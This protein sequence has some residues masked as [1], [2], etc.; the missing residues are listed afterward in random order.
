[1]G[2]DG[3]WGCVMWDINLKVPRC[4]WGWSTQWST[5]HAASQGSRVC[6]CVESCPGRTRP[7][8]CR[9]RMAALPCTVQLFRAT[10]KLQKPW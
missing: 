4:T 5:Q 6:A 2:C 10:N 8:A 1:M 7:A 3:M 9:M